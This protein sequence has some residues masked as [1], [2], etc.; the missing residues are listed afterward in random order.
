VPVTTRLLPECR[1]VHGHAQPG[2]RTGR[3]TAAGTGID[4]GHLSRIENGKRPPTA[5]IALACDAA[6]PER[7]GWFSEY[8]EESRRGHP[9]VS[10]HGA[11]TRTRP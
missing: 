9:P 3:C 7:K 1:H 6:F 10:G 4:A 8:Y 2:R 5:A 11:S